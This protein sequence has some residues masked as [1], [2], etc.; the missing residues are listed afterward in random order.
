R[1][2]IRCSIHSWTFGAIRQIMKIEILKADLIY[3]NSFHKCL[4]TVCREGRFLSNLEAPPFE[5]IQTFLKKNIEESIPQL[6]AISEGEVV[7]WCDL[8]LGGR[9]ALNHVGILGMGLLPEHRGKGVGSILLKKTIDWAREKRFE[10]IEL[11]V[12]ASNGAAIGL[13]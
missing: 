9:A 6:F 3:L 1:K 10:K 4:D 11:E 2:Q 13:Y 12:F 5:M 8:R 7:G